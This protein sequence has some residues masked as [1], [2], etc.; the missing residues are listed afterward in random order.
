[1]YLKVSKTNDYVPIETMHAMHWLVYASE[2]A[3][4]VH[5]SVYDTIPI[6]R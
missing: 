1:M 6:F 4:T 5:Q 2:I 3:S